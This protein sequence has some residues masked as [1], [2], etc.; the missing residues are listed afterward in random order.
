[1]SF[2]LIKRGVLIKV[3]WLDVCIALRVVGAVLVVILRHWRRI[4]TWEAKAYICIYLI[5]DKD[6][7]V[8]NFWE[9]LIFT[10]LLVFLLTKAVNIISRA[11]CGEFLKIA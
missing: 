11:T 9:L 3:D 2:L 5:K 8:T 4:C 10:V 6:L 7:Q 1:L